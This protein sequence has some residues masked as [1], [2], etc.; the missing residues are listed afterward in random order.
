MATFFGGG[1]NAD[2][3]ISQITDSAPQTLDT[4]N[5]LAAALN[6]DANFASTVSTALA[7]KAESLRDLDDVESTLYPTTLSAGDTIA[8]DVAKQ[9]FG[10]VSARAPLTHT[11]SGADVVYSFS[12]F[13]GS[14]TLTSADK[15]KILRSISTPNSLFVADVLQVGESITFVQWGNA[16][17]TF[18]V[19]D[20]ASLNLRSVDGKLKSNKA[21]SVVQL[22]KV[23]A[24]EYL[25]FGDLAA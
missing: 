24:D 2:D 15:G 14:T 8:F 9:Q 25:L 23:A 6:D 7:A 13:A 16:Q 1:V 19:A 22:I 12:D 4:L 10:K 3:I 17:I 18:Y 20:G 21:Y 11:H 5:E